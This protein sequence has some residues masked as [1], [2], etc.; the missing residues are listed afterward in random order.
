M[1][2][3]IFDAHLHII[4]PGYPLIENNGFLP[5]EFTA[6]D[7]QQR[8][9]GLPVSGGA[10]VSGSFQGF[11]Q[12]YLIAALQELGP[13]YVGVT[14]IPLSTSEEDIL[15][16]DQA[17][18]RAVR[19]N[20]F[21]GGSESLEAMD[22][23]ARKVYEVAGWH[24]ELYVDSRDLADLHPKLKGLPELSIDHLGMHEE[25]L[26]HLLRLVED[27][28]YVKATGF[29]R[30]TMDPIRVVQEIVATNPRALM[31]GTDLPSTRARRPF[32]AEDFLRVS[33]AI[34]PQLVPEIF[35]GNAA[36]LYLKR[37]R[38]EG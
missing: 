35:W 36:S 23:L 11:D 17:G 24:T 15:R 18:V 27:G 20:L 34:D 38:T 14:Q 13:N 5:A 30:I 32:E 3:Q 28:A 16:L 2:Q 26:P 37:P 12:D 9:G 6:R 1:P 21:R 7:Y 10:V 29:G 31:V 25:G 4:D 8:L 33:Q 19:F 22:S